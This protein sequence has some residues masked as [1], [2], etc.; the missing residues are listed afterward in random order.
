MAEQFQF[1]FE[2]PAFRASDQISVIRFSG[3]E[4]LS[5]LF[6]FTIEL[7]STNPDLDIEKILNDKSRANLTIQL[8]NSTRTI[9]G[10]VAYFEALR[11][12]N[13]DTIYKATLVP[14]LWELSL[15]HT[16]EVYFDQTVPQI[17]ETV[18]Q[19]AGFTS[20]DY[21]LSGLTG[22]YKIWPYKCQY[23]ETHMN[24][25]SRLMERDGIYY[26]FS[27]DS[28]GEKIIFCDSL[29]AHQAIA[30]PSL[31][32]S[33]A[34]SM[35]INARGSQVHSFVSQQKRI[36]YR[37]LLKDFNDDKPTV[38]IQGTAII[39][40]SAEQNSEVYVYG[41]NIETPEEGQR[42]AD[43]RAEEIRSSKHSYHGES[44]A[45]GLM[46]GFNFTLN[47]HFRRLCNQDYLL[48]NLHHEGGDSRGMATAN[49]TH[50]TIT[51][52]NNSFTAI[53][54]DVQFRPAQQTPRP[55]IHGTLNAFVDAEGD[56]QYA[57]IDD[58]GRYR[59]TLPFDRT[60]RDGGKASPWIR[61]SQP[62]SGENQGMHFPLR[63]GAAVL[64][65]F[66]GGDPDRPV[67]ANAIP[68]ASQP[69][70]V[71]AQNQ[72]NSMIKTSSGNLIELEDKAEKKRIKLET[73][74]RSTYMHLGAANHAGDGWVL[75]SD[76]LERRDISGGQHL[77]VEALDDSGSGDGKHSF[78][79]MA[80]M[81]A[82]QVK[83]DDGSG[84]KTM[85]E[86][87]EF[88]GKYLIERRKG[89]KYLWTEG[90][91]YI[92]G[93]GNVFSF[94]SSYSEIHCNVNGCDTDE[95]WPGT[96]NRLSVPDKPEGAVRWEPANHIVEKIWADTFNYQM[97]SN[98]SWGDTA[99]YA[100]GSSYE[101]NHMDEKSAINQKLQNDRTDSGGPSWQSINSE[102]LTG[103]TNGN[104]WVSKSYGNA[105][106]FVHGNSLEVIDGDSECHVHGAC[107]EEIHGNS[108]AHI[109]GNSIEHVRGQSH[110][111]RHGA[112]NEMFLGANSE[113]FFGVANTMSMAASNEMFL[114]FQSDIKL[115]ATLE[116]TMGGKMEVDTAVELKAGLTKIE[117]AATKIQSAAT[118]LEAIPVTIKSGAT[119]IGTGL[120]TIK[121]SVLQLF[122]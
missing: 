35:N 47:H 43:I 7:K 120:V 34:S 51:S 100:F 5:Q 79:D 53:P 103:M 78:E 41:Q 114:G 88:S 117:N 104:V 23:N 27:E 64:L 13:N 97:G 96:N 110:S 39:D 22:N 81:Y 40:S 67:I 10:I 106:D 26:Y 38:D 46:P 118:K 55:E 77:T 107:Y 85:T 76:G 87:V 90:H 25:I 82:F 70:V 74:H 101:E 98:Y 75:V 2:H 30:S 1:T 37:I 50:S 58:E 54:A 105:Y 119:S 6:R 93:G 66:I 14:R 94:G 69:S 20:L 86:A 48:L 52:Y 89:N 56:G 99:D 80:A 73:P 62:F 68:N 9:H 11:Q 102:S 49:N 45:A 83:A 24:F 108:T 8:G 113:M 59:I 116:V 122:G 16:N 92:Y 21:D 112:N 17:I 121:N 63:K 12:V 32:Y 109:T 15:F 19:E 31:S 72:T 95:I 65:T 57:E 111:T 60:E 44:T 4:G 28:D 18:L 29:H 33:P 91:E 115:A 71:N 42:L 84:T 61:M 36:P 3:D